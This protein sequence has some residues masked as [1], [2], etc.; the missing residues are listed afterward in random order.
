MDGTGRI[1]MR[2]RW[3]SRQVLMTE[4]SGNLAGLRRKEE[5]N[6]VAVS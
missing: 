6:M 3:W 4:R 5:K 2:K 1:K